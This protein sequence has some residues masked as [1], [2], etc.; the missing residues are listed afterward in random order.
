MSRS[1]VEADRA[2]PVFRPFTAA[3]AGTCLDIFDAN[4][5]DYFAPNERADFAAFLTSSPEGY[6]LCLQNDA[7]VGAFGL[8]VQNSIGTLNW[9]LLAPSAHGTGVG[10]TIMRRVLKRSRDRNLRCVKIAASHKSQGFFSKFGAAT[11]TVT[12]NGWGPGMHRVDMELPIPSAPAGPR[13]AQPT[14]APSKQGNA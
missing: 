14:A 10:S 5:P 7:P 9:I 2:P 11:L 3:D 8:T 4:C 1:P 6:E 12:P 13:P